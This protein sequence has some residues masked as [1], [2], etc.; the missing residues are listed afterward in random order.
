M[1]KHNILGKVGEEFAAQWLESNGYQVVDRNWRCGRNELD[2]V[3]LKDGLVI[4]F[5]VKTRSVEVDD[6]ALLLPLKK[7]KAILSSGAKWLAMHG[8]KCEIRFDLLVIDA[9]NSKLTH[10]PEAIMVYDV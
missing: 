8:M 2:M 6:I 10:Y 1:A 9:V 3:A 5:E 4:V 7:R